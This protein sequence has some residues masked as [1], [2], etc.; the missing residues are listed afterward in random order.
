MALDNA[1][2]GGFRVLLFSQNDGIKAQ[3]GEP[4]L[5]L[6]VDFG[7]G[8]LNALNLGDVANETLYQIRPYE[9][10]R[11][12]TDGAFAEV[13][14]ALST[15]LCE[16]RVGRQ[17]AG[18]AGRSEVR[19]RGQRH[20]PGRREAAPGSELGRG[21]RWTGRE[22]HHLQGGREPLQLYTGRD[23]QLYE[24]VIWTTENNRVT[25]YLSTPKSASVLASD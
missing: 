17:L 22:D 12:E 1:G 9:V 7:M 4:G 21:A 19:A 23:R 20:I 18:R 14:D 3:S 11:G 8:M 24:V 5:K 13:M 2:F 16:R 15:F 10:V 6:S 25:G